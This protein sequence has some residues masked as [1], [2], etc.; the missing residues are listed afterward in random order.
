M[1]TTTSSTI[2]IDPIDN[3]DAFIPPLPPLLHDQRVPNRMHRGNK[4]IYEPI[5]AGFVYPHKAEPMDEIA[6]EA[7][8]PLRTLYN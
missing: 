6:S 2:T 4:F 3:P 5:F 1:H 8:V 7:G